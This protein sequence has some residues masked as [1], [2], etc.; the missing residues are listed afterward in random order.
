MDNLKAGLDTPW[1]IVPEILQ[2]FISHYVKLILR[3]SGVGIGR[4]GKF[5]GVPKIH[6][7]RQSSITIG[8]NFENRNWW[9]SNPLG[10]NHSLILTTWEANANIVIGNDVGVSGGS[11]CAASGIIIGDG[12]LIGANCTIID[13]DFHP[14]KSN[15][16]RYSRKNIRTAPILIGKNVFIGTGCIIL[17]GVVIPDNTVVPAGSVIRSTSNK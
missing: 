15:N 10:I 13:T 12:T 1:K 4:Q 3:I 8:D 2:I 14:L 6:R 5:Y 17:K 16:R 7:H 11:I 9:D